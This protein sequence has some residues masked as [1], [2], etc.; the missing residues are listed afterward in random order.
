MACEIFKRSLVWFTLKYIYIYISD[1]CNGIPI[2]IMSC[3]AGRFTLAT[4]SVQGCS[5]F[6]N[7]I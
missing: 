3:A 7:R 6:H 4:I 1:L 2:A 5:T